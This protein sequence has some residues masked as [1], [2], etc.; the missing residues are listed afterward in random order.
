MYAARNRR[1]VLGL[2]R[3]SHSQSAASS[4]TPSSRARC[5]APRWCSVDGAG[6]P[7][8]GVANKPGSV[9]SP[10]KSLQFA[11]FQEHAPA[12]ATRSEFALENQVIQRPNTYA[13]S[14]CRI[15]PAPQYRQFHFIT[16]IATS[17]VE[18]PIERMPS[19]EIRTDGFLWRE[20]LR[21]VFSRLN[22]NLLALFSGLSELV[23]T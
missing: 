5:L 3:N 10:S 23:G 1:I 15:S 20:K 14:S 21:R 18:Y 8:I 2:A 12:N 7:G 19:R 6:L 16:S 11:F 13:Q 9:V 4:S 22:G 17:R